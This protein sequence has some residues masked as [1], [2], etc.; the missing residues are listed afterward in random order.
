MGLAPEFCIDHLTAAGRKWPMPAG[1][2]FLH[3]YEFQS[4]QG[5]VH[6]GRLSY[7]HDRQSCVPAADTALAPC[8]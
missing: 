5:M 3:A 8:S 6:N 1:G 4:L 2:M 7:L